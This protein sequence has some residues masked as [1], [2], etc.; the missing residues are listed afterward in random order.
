M[1]PGIIPVPPRRFEFIGAG[2]TKDQVS[3]TISWPTG[4][5]AGDIAFIVWMGNSTPTLSGWTFSTTLTTGGGNNGGVYWK[6]LTSSDISTPQ[7][8]TVTSYGFWRVFVFRGPSTAT[9]KS[10]AGAIAGTSA[11]LSGFT[12]ASGSGI[13]LAIAG[14]RDVSSITA[15][16]GWNNAGSGT[17]TFFGHGVSWVHS[18][19]YVN[20]TSVTVNQTSPHTYRGVALILELTG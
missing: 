6:V 14:D 15:V 18:D 7:T 8:N 3:G 12:K 9:E 2:S 13:V 4:T 10:T 11:S 1:I 20:S 17:S 5:Q 19:Q 16:T